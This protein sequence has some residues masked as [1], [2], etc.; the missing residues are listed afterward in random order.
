M[1]PPLQG[2]PPTHRRYSS[3]K[4]SDKGRHTHPHVR[5]EEPPRER[6]PRYARERW[7]VCTLV[8]STDGGRG[9]GGGGEGAGVARGEA[10]VGVL[11][12]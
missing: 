6:K 7:C 8:E 4:H 1:F 11:S 12:S 2:P 5:G 9:E 3:E 10:M